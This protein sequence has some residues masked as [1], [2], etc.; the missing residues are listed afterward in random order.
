MI[1]LVKD[2]VTRRKENAFVM[3]GMKEKIALQRAARII[4]QVK[5]NV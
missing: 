3:K 4:V 5:G 2:F 1:A